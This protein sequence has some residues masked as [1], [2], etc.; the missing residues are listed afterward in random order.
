MAAVAHQRDADTNPNTV[1][2]L[3]LRRAALRGM[4]TS[5]LIDTEEQKELREELVSELQTVGQSMAKL[6][7]RN[8]VEVCAK[9]DI[10]GEEYRPGGSD[11]ST[12]LSLIASIRRDIS[13]LMP[14]AASERQGYQSVRSLQAG[15]PVEAASSSAGTEGSS[16]SSA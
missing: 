11:T 6:S 9:L 5:P 16:K 15:R 12:A 10:L 14:R 7:S 4:L 3:G 8:P 13:A 2:A 1:A